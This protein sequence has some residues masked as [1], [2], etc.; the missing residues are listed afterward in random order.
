[1]TVIL[2][3]VAAMACGIDPARMN[4]SKVGSTA[5]ASGWE[6]SAA[7]NLCASGPVMSAIWNLTVSTMLQPGQSFFSSSA[8]PSLGYSA[9]FELVRK[10]LITLALPSVALISQRALAAP[11]A[12]MYSPK[13]GYL[14]L[15]C[16]AAVNRGV[17]AQS[18][19][20]KLIVG[21]PASFAACSPPLAKSQSIPVTMI[22]SAFAATAWRMATL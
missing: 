22:A 1:M 8:K 18:K 21:M 4:E 6:S 9:V 5:F 17:P 20:P 15:G 3:P 12:F 14:S 11:H 2:R 16:T 7:E 13:L 10:V 19:L